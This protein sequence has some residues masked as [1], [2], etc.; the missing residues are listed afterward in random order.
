MEINVDI[1]GTFTDCLATAHDGTVRTAK[2][3]TTHHDLSIGFL[4]AVGDIAAEVGTDVDGLLTDTHAIRYATTLGTNALIERNGPRLGLLTTRGHEDTVPIGRCRQWADG[5]PATATRDLSRAKRPEPLVEPEQIAALTE[6]VDS[7]GE[8]L[9]PLD[10]EEI[11][12]RV[13]DL[14]DQG[15]RGFVVC[16]LNAHINPEHE[17]LVREIIEEEY[18]NVYLGRFPTI[19]SHE[20]SQRAGEYARS[21]TATINAYLHR[22][23]SDRLSS[24]RDELRGRGYRGE[25]LLVHN[26]GGMGSL[27][28]TTPIQ[29]VHA[30]PVSG[31]YGSRHLAHSK[32]FG[33]VVTTDMG[34]TSFDVGIVVDGSVRFYDFHPVIDRWHVQIPM[35]DIAAIGAGGGSIAR[36]DP[37][38]GIAVGPESAGSDPGPAC[39]GQ[40]GTEPTVTDA[41]LVL[42]YLDPD[43]YHGGKLPLDRRRAERAIERRIAKPLGVSVLEAA[44]QIRKVVD[45]A[46]GAEI[47]KGVTVKGYDPREFAVFSFGGGGPMHACGYAR[48]LDA[49]EVVVPPHSSVFS[50]SGAA[51]LERLHIYERSAWMV[52]FNPVVKQLYG[53]FDAFNSIV[54]EFSARAESDFAGQGYGRDDIETVV[55]LD[56][57]STGQ[58][59]VITIAS[60]VRRLET[61]DDLAA[62]IKTYFEE[63]GDRF[64]DLA[65]TKEVGI[66]IDAIRLR[67]W[68]PRPAPRQ[69]ELATTGEPVSRARKATRECWWAGRQTSVD[70]EIYDY[71]ALGPGHRLAGPAI[72]EA[73]NTNIVVEPGWTGEMDEYGFFTMR[74]EDKA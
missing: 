61:Q 71:A 17:K 23:T 12:D 11:R 5:L 28:G 47:F 22:F 57:R 40:G 10:P 26:S 45:E 73:P 18:P 13:G 42:G 6:R 25:L 52:L 54:D 50:A 32:G 74:Q 72:V 56:M 41:N 64:G 21:M 34:G 43:N 15:V 49:R 20:V 66:S 68:I 30:G 44:R 63:Y 33:K 29:T 58:L 67:A 2:A 39:Y 9:M 1:G 8:V 59:Y 60:P 48:A 51:G 24:L 14:V 55:E 16:L 35:M 38:T 70:T 37:I 53:D 62:I 69:A 3:L 7:R 19:L 46:M 31:L 36:V 4:R 27:A 65:L